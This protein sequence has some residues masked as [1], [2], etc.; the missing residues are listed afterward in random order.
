[1]F[2][3]NSKTKPL[4][5]FSIMMTGLRRIFPV[6]F[7]S[8]KGFTRAPKRRVERFFNLIR[9]VP[10]TGTTHHVLHTAEDSKTLV[11]MLI[12]LCVYR[13]AGASAGFTARTGALIHIR[14]QG[15]AIYGPSIV[16]ITDQIVG[17]EEIARFFCGDTL[18][19]AIGFYPPVLWEADIK[20]M[21]KLKENDE[22]VF[23]SIADDSGESEINGT[24]YLWFKE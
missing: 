21:R 2:A 23:S 10:S 9:Q 11:R 15:V 6:S 1:M 19:T 14:P 8:K 17:R 24:I 20:A 3:N 4:N 12:A 16:S 18:K 13:T 22:I 7:M 5:T